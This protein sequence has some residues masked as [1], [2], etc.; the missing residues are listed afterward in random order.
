MIAGLD[1]TDPFANH[2]RAI[3]VALLD[4]QTS[5]VKFDE[6]A[7]NPFGDDSAGRARFIAAARD[8]FVAAEV[9]V[10]DG[11]VGLALSM[12]RTR[13]EC[14]RGAPGRTPYNIPVARAFPFAGYIRGSILFHRALYGTEQVSFVGMSGGNV[15]GLIKLLEAYPGG[16]WP[17]LADGHLP[18]KSTAAGIEARRQLLTDC[19]LEFVLQPYQRLNHD[20]LDAALCAY[21]GLLWVR[22]PNQVNFEGVPL[23][24]D[25]EGN[26]RE[27]QIVQPANPAPHWPRLELLRQ[28]RRAAISQVVEPIAREQQQTERPPAPNGLPP[29]EWVYFA[30]PGGTEVGDTVELAYDDG[31]IHRTV[32]ADRSPPIPIPQVMHMQPGQLLLLCYGSGNPYQAIASCTIDTP[33]QSLTI[34]DHHFPAI[35]SVSDDEELSTCLD[36]LGYRRDPQ[37]NHHTVVC[38][39]ASALPE[40]IPV[41][42][43]NGPTIRRWNDVFGV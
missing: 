24:R 1:L 5:Q 42:R 31:V 15:D 20:R 21:L 23:S 13:R 18:S 6:L 38:V 12:E 10:V 39:D 25:A 37:V 26:L 32:F 30:T 16:A 29:H 41:V 2:P 28:P 36:N 4:V 40:P 43:P 7:W 9:W 8:R 3:D 17:K 35:K 14:E 11:P 33:E 19:G 27:G 22:D 34:D